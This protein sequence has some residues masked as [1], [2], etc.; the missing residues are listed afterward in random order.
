MP[1]VAAS[2]TGHV[3]GG[4]GADGAGAEQG[5]ARALDQGQQ[6]SRGAVVQQYEKAGTG[7]EAGV[8]LEAE[9]AAAQDGR[10]HQMMKATR[11]PDAGARAGSTC[12]P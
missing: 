2:S 12:R 4:N 5:T 11:Q 6:V 10:R 1:T 9:H 3:T 8:R 7:A